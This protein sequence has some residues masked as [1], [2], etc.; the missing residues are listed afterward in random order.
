MSKN[1]KIS[2]ILN[3]IV[4]VLVLL[5]IIFML[6]G[7]KFMGDDKLLVSSKGYENFK[8]FTVD[9]NVLMGLSALLFLIYYKKG[10]VPK[11]V[12]LL[13]FA[14]T[15]S[16]ALTFVTVV[17]Y[18]APFSGY[19]FLAFFINNNLFF[20]L[21]VPILSI[22]TFICFDGLYNVKN[23]ELLYGL[24]PMVLYSIYY[25][26]LSFTHIKNGVVEEGYDWYG[27]L[28][29]DVSVISGI[30][31]V[32]VMLGSTYLLGYLLNLANKKVN[33]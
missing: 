14:G 16:V 6:T 19:D 2:Y 13:K 15:V 12:K 22:V 31:V 5:G 27:F 32:L 8:F 1:K 7:F 11:W 29:K 26:A 30:V 20:H 9:S 10:E 3:S 18:L 4:I 24:V 28:G 17:F 23:K 33:K 21:I 25:M